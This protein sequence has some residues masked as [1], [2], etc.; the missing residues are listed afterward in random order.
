MY[1]FSS[2]KGFRC[3]KKKNAVLVINCHV[4]IAPR[5]SILGFQKGEKRRWFS[6][7]DGSW[8]CHRMFFG[9]LNWAVFSVFL[10]T[11]GVL[12]FLQSSQ[13]RLRASQ[14]RWFQAFPDILSYKN[15]GMKSN[16]GHLKP[17]QTLFLVPEKQ[18]P[19]EVK[20]FFF[21]WFWVPLEGYGSRPKAVFWW[22][23]CLSLQKGPFC[24]GKQPLTGRDVNGFDP[25]PNER[26]KQK[27]PRCL[28]ISLNGPWLI[29][30]IEPV[31][32]APQL[33]YF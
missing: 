2:S 29:K 33:N 6:F 17:T 5:R 3:Q 18:V 16:L 4:I 31:K 10:R 1:S 23:P 22:T 14:G 24:S 20:T 32:S 30:T 15:Q 7:S 28:Y 25:T 8:M 11:G 13:A 19:L 21:S 12:A 26:S 27:S 9:M